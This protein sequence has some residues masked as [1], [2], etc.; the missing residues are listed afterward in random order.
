MSHLF[1][2][3]LSPFEVILNGKRVTAFRSDKERALLAYICL[4]SHGPQRREKLAGLLWPDYPE[5]TARTYLRNALANIRKVI[6]DRPQNHQTETAPKFLHITRKS[7]QFNIESEAWVDALAF[8]SILEKTHATVA[9]LEAAVASYR[10]GFMAGFSLADSNLFEEWL[11]IQRE[12]FRGLAFDALYRLVEAYSTQDEYK[13]A[14]G[15]AR[16][17]IALDPLRESAQQQLMRLL[18]Y[19]GQPNQ[20]LVQYERYTALLADEIGVEP[21]DE[22][23]R[24]YLQIRDG[25]LTIPK[26]NTIHTPA[27]LKNGEDAP[28]DQPIFVGREKEMARLQHSF[29]QALAGQGQVV[30]IIGEPGSGKTFLA[31]EFIRQA[32]DSNADLL[33]VK[34]RCNAYTGFGDPYLPFLEMMGMLTGEIEAKWAGGE[35]TGQHARRLWRCLP[36][37]LHSLLENGPELIDRFVSGP[38]LMARAQAGAPEQVIR[39]VEILDQRKISKSE[40]DKLQQS[41]LFEQLTK[42]LQRLSW[43]KPLVLMVDDLQWAD[44]GSIGLLFHLGRKL[45][46]CRI[47]L[48]GA[49]RPEE[50]ALGRPSTDAGMLRHPLE[51]VLH[52]LQ[53]EFGDI[54]IDLD[55]SKNKNFVD[56]FIDTEPNC[57][58][59]HFREVLFHHTDGYPLFTVELLRGLQS[60]GDL[61]KDE[62]GRWRAES[63][64]N[65]QFL[66]VKVEAVIAERIHRLPEEWQS[67]LTAASVEGEEFTAEA[68]AKVME[69]DEDQILGCLS[70]PLTHKHHLVQA[71]DLEWL[72]DQRLSHYR[73]RHFLFQKY[74]Y[75]QLDPV[76]RAHLHQAVG[77]AL[78]SLHGEKGSKLAVPLALHFEEAGMTVKAVEYLLQA[79]NRAAR[80]FA[81]NEAIA[82]YR[83]GIGLVETMDDTPQREQLE[84]TLLL[85]L[86][87]P[88]KATYGYSGD[89]LAQIFRRAQELIHRSE[90]SHDLFQTLSGFKTY[91]M[92][93]GQF[94]KAKEISEELLRVA[95]Q[96]KDPG[97]TAF[98]HHQMGATLLYLGQ[99]NSFLDHREQM[100]S[101]Y[102]HERDRSLVYQTGLDA[103]LVSLSHA[104]YAYWLLG[105]PDKSKEYSMQAINLAREWD[106]PFLLSHAL[107]FG[108]IL[109]FYRRDR[110][111]AREMAQE[112]IAVASEHGH[113]LWLGGG[114]AILGW[115]LGEEGY[116]EE[117]LTNIQR[118]QVILENIGA[119]L[120]YTS[121]LTVLSEIYLNAGKK[122][123]G[124]AVVDEAL[125]QI[126]KMGGWMEEP[127]VHRLKGEL[128]LLDE[129]MEGEAE[130]CFQRAIE[131]AKEQQAKSW[132]LRATMSLCR[133]LQ[134]QGRQEQALRM[135]AE[136]Y[137]WF[138]EG[139]DTPDLQE[140]K[141]LLEA[142]S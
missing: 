11:V 65:W 61:T 80:L 116:L 56:A 106:N 44:P 12:R 5:S 47:L 38:P 123:D 3:L 113:P 135:L 103:Q 138:T 25:G 97:L 32:M 128:L 81:N 86:T 87:V 99:P 20:A 9:E 64:L 78:E 140:A 7:I 79:G 139:F 37:V 66:P 71:Q 129:A 55:K 8:L 39:L 17:L 107:M 84:L 90:A 88:L 100:T 93:R 21:L 136:I 58:S 111:T 124:L 109:A 83:H 77:T 48:I 10:D 121:D 105:Y 62:S 59:E 18:A 102:N 108:A 96:L 49:Y 92:V 52:E 57:L 98:A 127:E 126:E 41:E 35:I 104:G 27:F 89:E 114:L 24:L 115:V 19:D 91:Y 110:K 70:G 69:I 82:H 45:R 31:N 68:I 85:A 75:D 63:S 119:W 51:S 112:T 40:A 120:S 14:L 118:G 67:I 137:N 54:F 33:A 29:D 50:V 95:A 42:T 2:R 16:R 101:L 15:H 43:Q 134:K 130:A 36:N 22:T 125:P 23:T 131:V 34:G 76:Q 53:G 94:I 117:A 142:L 4:E 30:F 28:A 13:R 26:P 133:L 72:G 132:E 74:L 46:G 141:S 60:R 73:F 6:G 1:I 122:K